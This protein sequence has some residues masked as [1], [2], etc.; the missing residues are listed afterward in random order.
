MIDGENKRIMNFFHVNDKRT[1][2]RLVKIDMISINNLRNIIL[3][4]LPLIPNTEVLHTR[5]STSLTQT[6]ISK[7]ELNNIIWEALIRLDRVNNF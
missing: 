2:Q 6:R 3:D 4:I 1:I 7:T 5:L